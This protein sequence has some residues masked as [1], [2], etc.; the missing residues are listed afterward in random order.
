MEELGENFKI[1]WRSKICTSEMKKKIVRTIVEEV[2]ANS[3]DSEDKLVFVI[4]WKG[5]SHTRFE[6]DRP[7]SGAGQKTSMEDLDVIRKMGVR[8]GDD[9][10]ARVLNKLGRKTGKGKRWNEQRV[11][12]IRYRSSIPGQKRTKPDPDILTLQK[13]AKYC[14]CQPK[15]H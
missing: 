5:G 4:H 10:I 9:E 14:K 12:T 1:V 2:V 11:K 7:R 6:M 8:Y 13:A 3:N 15:Y